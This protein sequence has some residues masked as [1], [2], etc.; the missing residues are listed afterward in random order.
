[1]VTNRCAQTLRQSGIP[2]AM[3]D[4]VAR[5]QPLTASS[6]IG[7]QWR[8]KALAIQLALLCALLPGATGCKE[9]SAEL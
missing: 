8:W 7:R 3:L 9:R 5:P 2:L 1:M 4:F 6:P